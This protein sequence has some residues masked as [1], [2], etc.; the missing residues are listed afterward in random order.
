MQFILA[1]VLFVVVVGAIDGR[2][3]WPRSNGKQP[4]S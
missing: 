2:L 1:V 3:P 4:R